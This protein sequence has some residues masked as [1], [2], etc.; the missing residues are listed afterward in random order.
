MKPAVAG[1]LLIFAFLSVIFQC[2]P[3]V[4]GE[5]WQGRKIYFVIPD[6]FIDA[7]P[8]N[9][10]SAIPENPRA[11]HGGDL[12]G[13][14]KALPAVRRLGFDLLWITPPMLNRPGDF[15]GS[16]AFHGYWIHDFFKID[17]RLGTMEDI[18]RLV[19]RAHDLG[20][21][22]I[23]DFVANHAEWDAPMVSSNPEIFRPRR[24]ISDWN[25]QN[26]IETGTQGGLPDFN[27]SNPA[28]VKF[29]LAA[30]IHWFDMTGCDGFRMDSARHVPRNFWSEFCDAI[31][32]HAARNGRRDFMILGEVLHG[33]PDYLAPYS[34]CG[35]DALY[36][37]PGYYALVDTLTKGAP[38]T[39][40]ASIRQAM[41]G[42]CRGVDLL[43]FLDNH[44]QPR[45]MTLART[46]GKLRSGLTYAFLGGGVPCVYYGT[47]ELMEGLDD[48]VGRKDMVF[49]M[50]LPD[51]GRSGTEKSTVR[52]TGMRE[53]ESPLDLSL[54]HPPMGE[55]VRRLSAVSRGYPCF[56]RGE[57]FDLHFDETFGAILRI[58]PVSGQVGLV[59][60]STS[61]VSVVRTITLIFPPGVH[62]E[63]PAADLTG[64]GGRM[65]L[66][67][68]GIEVSMPAF[69]ASA[70][71][72][73]SGSGIWAGQVSGGAVFP[74]GKSPAEWIAGALAARRDMKN[75]QAVKV[76]IVVKGIPGDATE[77]K[78]CGD[79]PLG[80][81]N[82][83]EGVKLTRV[84]GKEIN[85][86]GKCIS[87]VDGPGG[88]LSA[89]GAWRGSTEVPVG[90]FI[91]FKFV[92][93]GPRGTVWDETPNRCLRVWGK[94][95]ETFI[96]GNGIP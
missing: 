49:T 46:R 69:S 51:S 79:A 42:K 85:T 88:T 11:F 68:G 22:V 57:T 78:V 29:L 54:W 96:W 34:R 15:F 76:E 53:F 28:A 94:E 8:A 9:D 30:A 20:M 43:T 18:R 66:N 3:A 81:W 58:D 72:I 6:R 61:P 1:F 52:T 63:L 75:G 55:H 19:D 50:E 95:I 74:F 17:P 71:V 92:V 73:W 89:T 2:S 16:W 87:A 38:L 35:F 86:G 65:T 83:A 67:P 24:E 70:F 93:S 41:A 80:S 84:V 40:L 13:L 60:L 82:S 10:G 59:T 21:G 4:C 32:A 27:Q 64:S 36:D 25:D 77:V 37:Y 23:L 26:D 91:E 39:R 7:D 56:S 90:R 14:T 62:T 31:K 33:D 12:K 45:F 5:T 47:E 48:T 44:D